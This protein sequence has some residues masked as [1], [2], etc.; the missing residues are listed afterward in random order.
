MESFESYIQK[1]WSSLIYI[2]TVLAVT[3]LFLIALLNGA[4]NILQVSSSSRTCV[5]PENEFKLPNSIQPFSYDLMLKFEP[6]SPKS[7]IFPFQNKFSGSVTAIFLVN[8]PTSCIFFNSEDLSLVSILIH[9]KFFDH[10]K[11]QIFV[12]ETIEPR[13]IFSSSQNPGLIQIQLPKL[14]QT[15]DPMVA[16]WLE[17]ILILNET[18]KNTTNPSPI[19]D[20]FTND[21]VPNFRFYELQ[22]LYHGPIRADFKGLSV[23][24]NG[25]PKSNSQI[26]EGFWILKTFLKANAARFLFPCFDSPEMK[27]FFSFEILLSSYIFPKPQNNSSSA[28]SARILLFSNMKLKQFDEITFGEDKNT[29]N[30]RVVVADHNNNQLGDSDVKILDNSDILAVPNTYKVLRFENLG[31]ISPHEINFVFTPKNNVQLAVAKRSS[32]IKPRTFECHP[33]PFFNETEIQFE[34]IMVLNEIVT[35]ILEEA[36]GS[37]FAGYV[38]LPEEIE[39]KSNKTDTNSHPKQFDFDFDSSNSNDFHFFQVFKLKN[40]GLNHKLNCT[41]FKMELNSEFLV[42]GNK[43]LEF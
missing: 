9:E 3:M 21:E 42:K 2:S 31:K 11:N 26:D 12:K 35:D 40:E 43:T 38:T 8:H 28:K 6:Q 25:K 20:D 33:P 22:I 18:S 37:N 19:T 27:A 16:I 5:F 1:N 29:T 14:L 30:S 41:S 32:K 4:S 10:S 7:S 13:Y 34:K 23:S 15:T 24:P 36:Y 17:S 39:V